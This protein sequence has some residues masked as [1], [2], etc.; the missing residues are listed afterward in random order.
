MDSASDSVE[1]LGVPVKGLNSLMPFFGS[2]YRPSSSLFQ[3]S[4]RCYRLQS[5][6]VQGQILGHSS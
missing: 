3:V 2:T 4:F 6:L 1:K 5:D